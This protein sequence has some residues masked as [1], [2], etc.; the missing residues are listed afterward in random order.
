MRQCSSDHIGSER[1]RR[2]G[3]GTLSDERLAENYRRSG[4]ACSGL[5][6]DP[7]M[8]ILTLEPRQDSAQLAAH[9]LGEFRQGGLANTLH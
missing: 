1:I 4:A 3:I 5:Q 6:S 7:V 9:G 8:N 2:M